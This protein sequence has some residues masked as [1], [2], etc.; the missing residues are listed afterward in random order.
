MIPNVVI[1][2]SPGAEEIVRSVCVAVAVSNIVVRTVGIRQQVL[3]LRMSNL[4]VVI[5]VVNEVVVDTS[6]D[7]R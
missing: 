1:T 5:P 6:V 4:I 3:Q 2:V 7:V